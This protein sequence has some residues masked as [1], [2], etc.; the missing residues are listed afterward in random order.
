M[1][2]YILYRI[3]LKIKQIECTLLQDK[4]DMIFMKY[5]FN[6][7][8]IHLLSIDFIFLQCKFYFIAF[9][10]IRNLNNKAMWLTRQVSMYIRMT[11]CVFITANSDFTAR[12]TIQTFHI[13][14]RISCQKRC[15]L[16]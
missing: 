13:L 9:S 10:C 5:L 12:L 3:H 1:N 16:A 2:V 4:K 15:F 8:S 6:M 14:R 7:K 11:L